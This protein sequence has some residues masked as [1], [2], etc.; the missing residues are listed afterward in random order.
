[1]KLNNMVIGLVACLCTGPA[2]AQQNLVG[3]YT[4]NFSMRERGS[5]VAVG[6]SVDIKS[7]E[8]NKVK[9]VAQQA[10]GAGAVTRQC[11]GNYEL[12]GTLSGDKLTLRSTSA[13][14]PDCTMT[15]R[16]VAD[17]N[18]LKGQIG[19]RDVELTK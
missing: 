8:D 9:A 4:G 14:K 2:L 10:G 1:M 19:S 5:E 17:G 12:E 13:P 15:L 11:A 3:K 16:L 6:L 7:V 18:K